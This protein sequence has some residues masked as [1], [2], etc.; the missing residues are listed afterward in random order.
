MNKRITL[1][2]GYDSKALALSI[3]A[4]TFAPYRQSSV[5]VNQMPIAPWWNLR[6]RVHDRDVR[7]RYMTLLAWGLTIVRSSYNHDFNAI[8]AALS[9]IL[10]QRRLALV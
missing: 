6:R 9:K 4:E 5:L 10:R 3:K 1:T 7:R 8:D 2:V